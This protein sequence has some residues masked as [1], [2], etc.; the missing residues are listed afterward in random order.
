MRLKW[1][2]RWLSLI[3]LL[4]LSGACAEL[5]P[6][7]YW[8]GDEWRTSTPEEQGLDSAQILKML[9]AIQ[10]QNLNIHSVLII[11]HGYL[12]TEAYFPP[13]DATLKQPAFSMTKSVTSIMAGK[14][15]EEGYLSGVGQSPLD[16][17]PEIERGQADRYLKDLTLEHLLTMSAG[18][19]TTTLPDLSNKPADFNTGS[20][21]LTY[22]SIL[23]K[24]GTTFFY[25]NGLPTS[26]RSSCKRSPA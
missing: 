15:V 24:P 18:Y 9:Q 12:V 10:A 19:N 6:P 16:F 4:S 7:A 1:I 20:F 5:T 25:D 2:I 3:A 13:Y 21:I 11:R 14:A 17:F 26:C 8:P 23:W 22:D